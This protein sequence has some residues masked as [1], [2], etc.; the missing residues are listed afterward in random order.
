MSSGRTRFVLIVSLL[1]SLTSE[2]QGDEKPRTAPGADAER[3]GRLIRA[4]GSDQFE[5]RESASRDLER[6]GVPALAA[7]RKAARTYPDAEVR[8]RAADLSARIENGLDQL[9]ADYRFFGLP[10]PP[11]RAPLVRLEEQPG[12]TLLVFTPDGKK[13]TIT[14]PPP[15]VLAF[16]VEPA[17]KDR[18]AKLLVGTRTLFRK[19]NQVGPV[20]DS[21]RLKNN[22]IETCQLSPSEA[23]TVA[24][25]M[26]ARGWTIAE[27]LLQKGFKEEDDRAPRTAL[28]LLAWDYWNER[29]LDPAADY[30]PAASRQ[31][32][33][34]L[35]D[36]RELDT[37]E[38]RQLLKSLE[39][40]LLPS[41][42]KAG[43]MAALIDDLINV[44]AAKK[45]HSQ[46]DD[47]RYW[48]VFNLG[49]DAVPALIKALADD[50][51]THWLQISHRIGSWQEW[52]YHY[53][54]RDL[55][56]DLLRSIAGEQ[57]ARHWSNDRNDAAGEAR[58]VKAWWDE[59]QKEGEEAYLLAHVLPPPGND[60]ARDGHYSSQSRWPDYKLS[61]LLA[62]KYPLRLP[63]L[64]R[65]VLETRPHTISWPLT[66]AIAGSSLP[67]EEKVELLALGAANKSLGHRWAAMEELKKLDGDRF[68]TALVATLDGLP[69]KQ[70]N[71]DLNYDE[72]DFARLV[73]ASDDPRAWRALEGTT[74]RADPCLRMEILKNT[75]DSATPAQRRLRL[76]FLAAFLND[77]NVRDVIANKELFD[78]INSGTLRPSMEVRNFAAMQIAELR[79]TPVDPTPDWDITTWAILR[80]RMS[81][82]AK[83]GLARQPRGK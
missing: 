28:R 15:Y 83:Y 59:A 78:S 38:N 12:H 51:L 24:L 58:D 81:V 16:L 27:T 19:A 7:L 17:A 71:L 74:L 25:Q 3:I 76:A 44:R 73:S 6:T 36:E 33:A 80:I 79:G 26:H 18:D 11:D 10:F 69:R 1:L 32:K 61:R 68:V 31:M 47:V 42:A 8:R 43:S 14:S 75:A 54:V 77:D 39:A 57:A 62:K 63:R 53:R 5:E 60:D 48:R 66:E 2:A 82:V 21:Q 35:A 45:W 13:E 49:F 23:M 65:T 22:D 46:P 64:Y 40:A 67:H 50:R 37:P 9:L 4:L 56:A 55:A 41:K 72:A 34:L 70:E 30:W 20:L 52:K 29:L